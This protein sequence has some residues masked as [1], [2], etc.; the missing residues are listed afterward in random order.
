M[1]SLHRVLVLAIGNPGRRDDGLGPALVERLL[2][3]DLPGVRAD[4]NYQLQP[5]DSLACADAE[6]VVFVDAAK[7]QAEA[8]RFEAIEPDYAVPAASHSLG[9][10]A[11]LA[12]CSEVR[13]RVP[14]AYLLSMR[15]RDWELGEGLSEDAAAALESAFDILRRFIDELPE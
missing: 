14:R 4:A 9:P 13:G 7:D 11:V 8:V 15:G 12:I 1:P 5:E 2:E 6:V 3:L 10:G